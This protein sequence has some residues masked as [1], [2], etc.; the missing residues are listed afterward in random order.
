MAEILVYTVI[1][2]LH[3]TAVLVKVRIENQNTEKNKVYLK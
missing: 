2:S 1:L 3:Y